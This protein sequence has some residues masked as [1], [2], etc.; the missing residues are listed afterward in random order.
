MPSLKGDVYR[1]HIVIGDPKQRWAK[2]GPGNEATE[3]YL[4]VSFHEGPEELPLRQEAVVTL[5][6]MYYPYE[7]YDKLTAGTT[8]TLREGAKVVAFGKVIE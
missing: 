7:G 6:L 4:G 2:L 5:T 3:D 1:P 8:F